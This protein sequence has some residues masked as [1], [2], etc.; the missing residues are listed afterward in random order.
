MVESF[1]LSHPFGA[2]GPPVEG[3]IRVALNSDNPSIFHVDQ[4]TTPTVVHPGAIGFNDH[5]YYPS[6]QRAQRLKIRIISKLVAGLGTDI[7]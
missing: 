5:F 4:K 7:F 1:N 3:R 2:D 6:P